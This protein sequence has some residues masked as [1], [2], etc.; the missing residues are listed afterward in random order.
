MDYNI[1]HAMPK[2]MRLLVQCHFYDYEDFCIYYFCG[3]N[4][5]DYGNFYYETSI[6]HCRCLSNQTSIYAMDNLRVFW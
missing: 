2:I 5:Y 6:L 1:H 3:G 4:F